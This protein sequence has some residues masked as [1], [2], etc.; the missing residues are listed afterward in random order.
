MR[1]DAQTLAAL[2]A[3][4]G[5]P[6][7]QEIDLESEMLIGGNTDDFYSCLVCLNIV[8]QAKSCKGCERMFCGG[9]ITNWLKNHRTC[10]N[11][12][13]D[14]FVPQN[15]SL[16]ARRELDKMRFKCHVCKQEY[17]YNK[18][19]EHQAVCNAPKQVCLMKCSP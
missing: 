11:C 8:W 3:K 18:A 7:A 19:A 13:A 14:N 9:C 5:A 4:F 1:P 2:K 10:P 12:K 6:A 15:P 17:N 16:A